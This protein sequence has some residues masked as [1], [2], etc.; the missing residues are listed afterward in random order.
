MQLEADFCVKW[1]AIL[2]ITHLGPVAFYGCLF[3]AVLV[4]RETCFWPNNPK[5]N[6]FNELKQSLSLWIWNKTF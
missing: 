3:S 1:E 5:K 6:I 4:R 2:T